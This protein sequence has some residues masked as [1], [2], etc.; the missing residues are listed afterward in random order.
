MAVI[1]IGISMA[2][3]SLYAGSGSMDFVTWL[4]PLAFNL[5]DAIILAIALGFWRRG[6]MQGGAGG[7]AI[8]FD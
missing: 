3:S 6:Y 4:M 7:I 1:G 8:R 2:T 5:L